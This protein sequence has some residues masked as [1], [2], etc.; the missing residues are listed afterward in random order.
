MNSSNVGVWVQKRDRLFEHAGEYQEVEISP[1][2]PQPFLAFLIV[3][4]SDLGH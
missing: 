3:P 1:V 4:L 2:T